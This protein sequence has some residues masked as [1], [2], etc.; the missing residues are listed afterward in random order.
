MNHSSNSGSQRETASSGSTIQPTIPGNTGV[1]EAIL[2][3]LIQFLK[4]RGW[5]IVAALVVG[6][7]VGEVVNFASVRRYTAMAQIQIVP[8]Q[9]SQFRIEQMPGFSDEDDAESIDTAISI[10]KSRSLAL[11]TVRSLHLDSNPDFV[12]LKQGRP[13]DLSVPAI[14]DMLAGGLIASL[15]INRLGHTS[16]IQVRA[17]ARKPALATLIANTLVDN[18]IEWT[19]RDNYN[20]TAKVSKWLELQLKDLKS[21]LVKSQSNIAQ[22]Q[23]NLGFYG[24][25]PTNSVIVSNLQELNKQVADAEADSLVKEAQLRALKSSPPDVN[26]AAAFAD[27]AMKDL[28]LRLAQLEAESS[29][30]SQTYGPAYPGLKALKAQIDQTKSSLKVAEHAQIVRAEKDLEAAQNNESMLRNL[31]KTEEGNAYSKDSKG[32]QYEFA[33]RDYEANRTLYDGLQE[34]LQEAGILAGLHSTA[35]HIVDNADVPTIPSHPRKRFNL[36]IGAGIGFVFGLIVAL[37]LEA[38]DTN[39]KSVT[40]IEESLQMPVLAAIPLVETEDLKPQTF[41]EHA[42][43]KGMSAWSKVAESLRGMRTSI[44]LSSPGSPPKVIMITSTRPAEGKSTIAALSAI[45]FALNG[46]RVLLI[47]ADLRRASMHSKFGLG[48]VDGLSSVLSG[49]K[50]AGDV[51]VEWRELAN[52]HIMTAGPIPPLPSELLGSQ[53]MDEML[54]ALRPNYDFIFID[55]PPAIAVTDASVLGRLI[56]AAILIVRYGEAH[57]HVTQRC[58]DLLDRSGTHI[59]GATVNAVNL[60]APEYSEYYGRKFYEY[61]GER[62]LNGK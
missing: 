33:K 44:L 9:S 48:K 34:R 25:D 40:D 23:Q 31:L 10:L 55:T 5:M 21:N 57:R 27:P 59:L 58:V 30:L 28:T 35:I 11:E 61:Y 6:I 20:S 47:D 2:E 18:Y 15:E 50:S 8:D 19:F 49:K 22:L 42:V 39:L 24:V 43:S 7:V 36:A 1:D 17:T 41:K 52:L 16:I 46:A 29:S 3:P 62:D 51:I 32:A 60:K 53:Q 26:Y 12:P 37:V 45:T 38:L 13:W 14:R 4:K 54:V 56:D